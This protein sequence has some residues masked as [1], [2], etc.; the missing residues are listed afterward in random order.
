MYIGLELEDEFAL[1]DA[2]REL[3]TA[4]VPVTMG[5][6]A[7]AFSR[8]VSGI[9]FL[10]D[11]AGNALELVH[12][13]AQDYKF[14]SPVPG[15]EFVA[16]HL[17]IGHMNLFVADLAKNYAFYTRILGF[18]LTDYIRFGPEGTL[19]FLRCNNRHHSL[20]LVEMGGVN[21]L[22][23]AMFEMKSIDDVG[24]ALDRAMANGVPISSSLGRHR[25]DGTL[26]FY[27]KSPSGFDVEIGC[28]CLQIDESW[29]VNEFCEGDVWGHH[30]LVDAV[31][32]SSQALPKSR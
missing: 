17:G 25:N 19:K 13:P 6:E 21:G 23:H 9:A 24:K 2:I 15:Q 30:G 12:G 3:E 27:M 5:T 7:Q 4:G 28:D 11:P 1:E 26:S 20:A 32:E 22:Q 16:G 31:I 10:E 29:T 8:A 18:R 14:D